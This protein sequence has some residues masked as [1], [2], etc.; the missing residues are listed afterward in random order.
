[1]TDL[2]DDYIVPLKRT[3]VKSRQIHVAITP[4]A[5]H[6]LDAIGKLRG[7]SAGY[8]IEQLIRDAAYG[9]TLNATERKHLWKLIEQEATR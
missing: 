4:E 6:Y 3:R 5:G 9:K 2:P 1:M 7:T 8:T